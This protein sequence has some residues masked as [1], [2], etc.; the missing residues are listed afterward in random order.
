MNFFKNVENKII[1]KTGLALF[2]MLFGAGNI[3]FPLQAGANSCGYIFLIMIGFLITGVCVPFIGLYATSLYNGNYW[4]FFSTL[5]NKTGFFIISFLMVI[6]GPLFAVPR[7]EVITYNVLFQYLPENLN[8]NILFSFFYCL[9]IFLLS[10]RDTKVI[11]ILG[12]ILSPIKVISF[13]ILIFMG[14]FF[15]NSPNVF[16]D[17]NKFLIFKNA[18]TTGYGSMDLLATFFVCG[19]VFKSVEGYS[20]S[21]IFYRRRLIV[22]KSCILG[23]C[24]IGIVYLGFI[25]IAYKNGFFLIDVP[26]ENMI[27]AISQLILGSFGSIFVCVCVSFANLAT[28]LALTNVFNNYLYEIVFKFKVPKIFCLIL[29]IIVTFFV[30]HLGFEKIMQIALPFLKVFYPSLIVLCFMNLIYKFKGINLIKPFVLLTIFICLF[31]V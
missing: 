6:I 8:S 7:T 23:S 1:I 29:N 3:V 14:C 18:L 31:F 27:G 30:S 21:N 12:L 20:D 11:D 5:G 16:F 28:G 19:F 22:I 26:T 13:F 9:V 4:K 24:L 10:Y 25:F 2:A 17:E 15:S